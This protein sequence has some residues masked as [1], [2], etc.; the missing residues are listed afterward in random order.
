VTSKTI[1]NWK[2]QFLENANRAF[3]NDKIENRYK[4]Q[5]E[6]KNREID[7]LAKTLGK[8]TVKMEWAVGKLKSLE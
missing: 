3:E 6:I 8:T 1:S 2:K 4:E 5:I 7:A